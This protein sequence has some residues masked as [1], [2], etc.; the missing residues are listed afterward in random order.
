MSKR[1]Y[2]SAFLHPFSHIPTLEEQGPVIVDRGEGVYIY[3]DRGRKYLEGNSGLWNVVLGFDN[4]RLI[5]TAQRAY[6]R[7]PAY[8]A[9]FGRVGQSAL[10]LS[11]RIVKLAPMEANR[12][13]YAN[14][15]SEANDTVVKLLWFLAEAEG[16][17]HRRLLLSRRNA[18]HGM[19]VMTASLTGKDYVKSA[20][21]LPLKEVRHLT[22]PHHWREAQ[23]GE[24][25]K[26]FSARL[27][28]ELEQTI[29]NTGADHIAGFFAEPVMGAGGVIPPPEG[30]FQAIQPVLGK[31]GIPLIADE[32]ICGFGRTGEFWGSLTYGI[33]PDMVVASK[34]ITAGFFPMGAIILSPE[35]TE[36]IEKACAKYEE[37]PTGFT[38]GAHPVGCAIAMT[39][40]DEILEGGAFANV[41]AVTPAFQKHLRAMADHPIVGEARGVGLMGALE[42]VADRK[43]KEPFAGSLDV[44]ERVARQALKNGLICRPLGQSIVLAP[45]FII[46]EKEIAE[47]FGILRRTLDEVHAGI[48]R[49]AA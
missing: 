17:P 36:R 4:K 22:C 1:N 8:H 2:P 42:M 34:V 20:S 14:S 7:L 31:Y 23:A 19:T 13:F 9:F 48:A 33:K 3:D 27:A 28:L 21:G 10:D 47:L 24:S 18:Y 25:E 49:K 35:M 12:V 15:G 44:S 41:K 46:T 11:E 6:A 29:R 32:V 39:A 38:T 5:E 43:T 16:K 40:L 45:P 26:D 37:L 30:Y